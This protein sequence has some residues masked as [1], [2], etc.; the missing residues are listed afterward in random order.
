[1]LVHHWARIAKRGFLITLLLGLLL[2]LSSYAQEP[3]VSCWSNPLNCTF[4]D[5]LEVPVRIFNSALG[6]AAFV[7]LGII[8]FAGSRMMWYY[9][10]ESPKQELE[11]AKHTLTRGIVGFAIIAGAILIVNTLLAILGAQN[12]WFGALLRTTYGIGF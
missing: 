7:L 2:P 6:L 9:L 8:V 11:N 5:L 3:F 12:T 1:M 10:A 4:N